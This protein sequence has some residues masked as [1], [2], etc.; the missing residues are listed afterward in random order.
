MAFQQAKVAT[1]G[2][3]RR[4][5][6]VAKDG[7]HADCCVDGNIGGHPD[8]REPGNAM[9]H[10]SGEHRHRERGTGNVAHAGHQPEDG[11]ESEAEGRPGNPDS[12]VEPGSGTTQVDEWIGVVWG[13]RR[14]RHH[15]KLHR[16]GWDGHES[17]CSLPVG[18]CPTTSGPLRGGIIP[19]PISGPGGRIRFSP[20]RAWR[21]RPDLVDRVVAPPYDVVNRAEA[22]ALAAG[23][24][25]SFLH[26]GRSDIDLPPETDPHDDRVYA[27]G[28]EN[29]DRVLADGTFVHEDAP[30][31]YL[32]ELTREGQ[33]QVGVVGCVHVD[34]YDAG[35]IRKHEKTRPD[36]EDD[37]TRHVLTL[38]AHAEPVFL[39]HRPEG[40]LAALNA[41]TMATTP[42]YDLVTYD[43]VR[44]RVW[45]VEATAAYAAAFAAM[46][47]CYVADGHHRCASAWRTGK[48]LREAN[49]N[50]TGDEDYNW[51][52]AVLFPSDQLTILAYHRVVKDLHG[53]TP[54][55]F[56]ARL[57]TVGTLTPTTTADP[58]ASGSFGV[59]VAGAWYSLRLDP[60]TVDAHDPIGSLDASLLQERI[61]API[62]GIGDVRTDQRIDFVGGIRG[63]GE[64]AQ[65]VDSGQDAVAFAMYPVSVA[66]LMAIADA[67]A[68]MPPKSTWFE[69]KL[70]SGFFVHTFDP[71]TSGEAT[72]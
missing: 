3:P 8:E 28:R 36:K 6:E 59:Y 17:A 9:A 22:A 62:L 60:A 24:P 11:V 43:G 61:L 67:D 38:S 65:R 4:V 26:V 44:Q 50:H 69:P 15:C 58:K 32:Y 42:L 7:D 39:T 54:A 51:F 14:W 1:V 45:R 64:L 56:L 5:E 18:G 27:K 25:L 52:L 21:P 12:I 13:R 48:A 72:Q 49:P 16:Q 53:L 57:A 2:L 20:F 34:D 31:F 71:M 35:L 70:K 19:R 30:A 41:A 29:L 66:Q 63:T 23:N 47:D 37:R 40:T 33:A 68:I 46:P 55:D 10:G